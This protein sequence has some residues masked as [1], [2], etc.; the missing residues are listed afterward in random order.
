[1]EDGDEEIMECEGGEGIEGKG[2]EGEVQ[3][4][5][6]EEGEVQGGK[7]A[8]QRL[9]VEDVPVDIRPVNLKEERIVKEFMEKGCGCRKWGG[10]HCSSSFGVEYVGK[11]RAAFAKLSGEHLDIALMDEM[12]TFCD[13]TS[14]TSSLNR[15][16]SRSRERQ[17][18]AMK[19]MHLNQPICKRMFRFLHGVGKKRLEN[20]TAWFFLHGL[21]PRVHGNK[22]RLP[23]NT[24]TISSVEHVMMFLL[25]YT[26]QHGLL[27]PGRVPG[28]SR[29]D[30]RLLPSSTSRRGIWK[31]YSAATEGDERY[32]V[33]AYSTFCKLW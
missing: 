9:V 29:S 27:L 8:M 26:E 17:R 10:R 24:L 20:V 14:M 22:N 6:G 4:G 15:N 32:H 1:M 21:S 28:Y 2:E 11:V 16:K 18:I 12:L 31:L 13:T 23:K 7:E 30:I 3:G 5:K 25:T 19:Y 33:V